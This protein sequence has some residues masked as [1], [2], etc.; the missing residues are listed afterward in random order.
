VIWPGLGQSN[1]TASISNSSLLARRSAGS[2]CLQSSYATCGPASAAT[3]LRGLGHNVTEKE[4][5]VDSYTYSGGT[6]AWYLARAIRRRSAQAEF[7]LTDSAFPSPSIAGVRMGGGH[8]IAI[9]SAASDKVTF[10]DPLTGE[11]TLTPSELHARYRF[12]GFFLRV[13]PGGN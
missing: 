7:V 6:E 12:T 11:S 13:K 2:V 5:A 9:E 4:L 8:F 3:L 10:V 1:A